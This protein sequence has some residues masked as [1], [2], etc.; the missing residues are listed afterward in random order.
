MCDKSIQKA[1]YKAGFRHDRFETPS[2]PG[3]IKE[4]ALC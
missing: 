2:M 4:L 1:E 3:H